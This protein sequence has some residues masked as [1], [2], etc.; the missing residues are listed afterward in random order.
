M[1]FNNKLCENINHI[2]IVPMNLIMDN[3]GFF[4][5]TQLIILLPA[6]GHQSVQH[7]LIQAFHG[8]S[9]VLNDLFRG[10]ITAGKG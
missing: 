5:L 3:K 7:T 9:D 8:Q 2:S 4:G 10:D 1:T 6:L